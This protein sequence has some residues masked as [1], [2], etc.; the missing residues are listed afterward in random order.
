VEDGNWHPFSSCQLDALTV[1]WTDAPTQIE[2]TADNETSTPEGLTLHW[3]DPPRPLLASSPT[4]ETTL[5]LGVELTTPPF[6]IPKRQMEA[7]YAPYAALLTRLTSLL[8]ETS[9]DAPEGQLVKVPLLKY[10]RYDPQTGTYWIAGHN[11]PIL[12]RNS[13]DSLTD[14]IYDP[15]QLYMRWTA[16]TMMRTWWCQTQACPV[17]QNQ[18]Y[19]NSL[20]G[21]TADPIEMGQQEYQPVLNA[22][23]SYAALRLSEPLVD[24]GFVEQEMAARQRALDENMFWVQLRFPLA[25]SSNVNDMMI[26]LDGLWEAAGPK[27]FWT[28]VQEYQHTYGTTSLSIADFETF[29]EQTTGVPRP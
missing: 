18:G 20:A 9:A 7:V 5:M 6:D 25:S 19:E 26:R 22:L 21:Y 14:A 23:A 8:K 24:E 3:E 4:Y 16:D 27:A 15:T 28:L 11:A 29:V 13:A 17:F 1:T 10:D 2:H 12:L